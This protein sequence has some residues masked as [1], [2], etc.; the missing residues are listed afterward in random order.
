[1]PTKGKAQIKIKGLKT[2]PKE[3]GEISAQLY[4]GIISV[5][6]KPNEFKD[7]GG[8]R[9]TYVGEIN[10][11]H[12]GSMPKQHLQEK[13][14]GY[15]RVV[16]FQH[17]RR[18]KYD[19]DSPK[20]GFR[21]KKMQSGTIYYVYARKGNTMKTM[22]MISAIKI[23]FQKS[24][25]IS[26]SKVMVNGQPHHGVKFFCIK[27]PYLKGGNYILDTVKGPHWIYSSNNLYSSSTY[28]GRGDSLRHMT[29]SDIIFVYEH[30]KKKGWIK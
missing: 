17:I 1:M 28:E 14:W 21:G 23:G 18:F 16:S 9:Y 10:G 3:S 20:S 15:F 6:D 13:G 19:P 25:I 5:K 8:L 2:V 29:R 24:Q 30:M 26:M 22:Q 11:P 7:I 12:L 4:Q 27:K